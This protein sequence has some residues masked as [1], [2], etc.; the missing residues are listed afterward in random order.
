M[1]CVRGTWR[2]LQR[3]PQPFQMTLFRATVLYRPLWMQR[4]QLVCEAGVKR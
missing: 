2:T 1:A 3:A 4:K